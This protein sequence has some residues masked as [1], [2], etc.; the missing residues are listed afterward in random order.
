[1]ARATERAISCA[2]LLGFPGNPEQITTSKLLPQGLTLRQQLAGQQSALGS[3]SVN[4]VEMI[5]RRI[6]HSCAD[7]VWEIL[8][9]CKVSLSLLLL[10]LFLAP[11]GRAQDGFLGQYRAVFNTSCNEVW[12]LSPG[13]SVPAL[14]NFTV[15]IYLKLYSPRNS[16]TAF[17]YSKEID[18]NLSATEQYELGLKGGHDKLTVWIF[19]EEITWTEKL[20]VNTW[21]QVCIWWK[22]VQQ[23]VSVYINGEEKKSEKIAKTGQ[24]FANGQLLLGCSG[25]PDKSSSLA[26]GMIGE[27]YMFRMWANGDINQTQNCHDGTIIRWRKDNW[28]YNKT[29][30]YSRSLPCDIPG[31]EGGTPSESDVPAVEDSSATHAFLAHQPVEGLV[32]L[33]AQILTNGSD[34]NGAN[35]SSRF[36]K[37]Q[38]ST[39]DSSSLETLSTIATER[40]TNTQDSTVST[41]TVSTFTNVI[42]TNVLDNVCN[43]S[44]LCRDS[45]FYMGT[46]KFMSG[47]NGSDTSYNLTLQYSN[48]TDQYQLKVASAALPEL[49]ISDFNKTLQ[50]LSEFSLMQCGTVNQSTQECNFTIKL[51]RQM[52]ISNIL[53]DLKEKAEISP[54]ESCCC[55]TLQPYS[56]PSSLEELQLLQCGMHEPVAC[57]GPRSTSPPTASVAPSH[58]VN[59]HVVPSSES[60]TL[61]PL[62]LTEP[63]M[64]SQNT[65]TIL[66]DIEQNT[67]VLPSTN[68]STYTTLPSTSF[69][70]TNPVFTTTSSTTTSSTST[71]A[72]FPN[73]T[74]TELPFT[75]SS[76]TATIPDKPSTSS[77]IN[78]ATDNLF[79]TEEIGT[80]SSTSTEQISHSQPVSIS[81]NAPDI[82]NIIS[83]L[84]G[85]L[86]AEAIAPALAKSMLDSVS[87][88]L[89]VPQSQISPMSK[90]IIKIVDAIGLKVN[91]SAESINLT[92]PALA[93]AALKVNSSSFSTVSFAIENS[94]DLQVSL[95]SQIPTHSIGSITLPSSIMTNLSSE[96]KRQASRITFNFFRKT[97]LFQDPSLENLSLI[98]HIISS[99]VA[100]LTISNLKTNVTVTLQNTKPSQVVM[101]AGP[102]KAAKLEREEQMKQSV[103]AITSQASEFY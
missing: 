6:H 86:T 29:A 46:V 98:S 25:N 20:D 82:E 43:L 45:V 84:E 71:P 60:A 5:V 13:I 90:R 96:D 40:L 9:K 57:I 58:S 54:I 92:S 10:N 47:E 19:G 21:Y 2:V 38:T 100:N 74:V 94:S 24:L 56:C 97:T 88:L 59:Q 78:T 17:V 37:A 36:G 68:E 95:G 76:T 65:T 87:S 31:Y 34:S 3:C 44:V 26:D 50:H 33:S 63:T 67:T 83:Q 53:A 73:T 23:E 55:S 11:S 99:S 72:V 80:P 42:G 77:A 27:L 30:R 18:G 51:D 15:C 70:A 66:P 35:A 32:D 49:K 75:E 16:W 102:M 62:P 1:M 69:K 101:E 7:R 85:N 103:A 4:G 39:S 81:T 14:R 61:F 93:L 52:N 79:P 89:S 64:T 48:N 28:V 12:T 8:V 22:S 41:S 91:F